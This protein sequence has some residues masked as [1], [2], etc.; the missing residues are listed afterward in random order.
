MEHK[1][2]MPRNLAQEMML[3]ACIR[4]VVG[5]NLTYDREYSEVFFVLGHAIRVPG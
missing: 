5:L 3:L 4:L 1:V 2:L